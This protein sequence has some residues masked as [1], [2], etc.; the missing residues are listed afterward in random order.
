MYRSPLGQRE[1]RRRRVYANTFQFHGFLLQQG[2][3]PG[4]DCPDLSMALCVLLRILFTASVGLLSE[5]EAGTDL[6]SA[7]AE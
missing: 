5:T 7:E 2:D 3:T 6:T 1:R 4:I